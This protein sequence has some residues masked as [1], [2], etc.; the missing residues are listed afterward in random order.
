MQIFLDCD[1]V[2]ADFDGYAQQLLGMN[3]RQYEA[4][5]HTPH[6]WE[7]LYSHEDYFYRLPKMPDADEFVL[8]VRMLGFD[9]II[10]TGIPSKDGSDWA[11]GQKTRWAADHFP[12]VPIICCKSREKANHMI[13]GKHN[14]LID[15]WEEYKHVWE[16]AG[17][18]FIT[19]TSAKDSLAKLEAVIDRL[20]HESLMH[21]AQPRI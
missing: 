9:P 17:G 12:D 1:G 2:L 13:A 4:E 21:D 11:I 16:Q 8:G 19:H 6:M 15:D 20:F 5:K 10:L 14:V 3:P 7:V 18:T